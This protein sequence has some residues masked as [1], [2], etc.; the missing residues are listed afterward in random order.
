MA[1]RHVPLKVSQKHKFVLVVEPSTHRSTF[2]VA[3][4]HTSKLRLS[5]KKQ[6]QDPL[7]A[8]ESVVWTW[9]HA[10]IKRAR[11]SWA[12]EMESMQA[13]MSPMARRVLLGAAD[14]TIPAA[15]AQ[16][17]SMSELVV[18]VLYAIQQYFQVNNQQ[19]RQVTVEMRSLKG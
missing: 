9:G 3:R 13:S 8:C 19:S 2:A 1:A 6:L 12:E 17:P 16:A 14:A 4:A 15:K 7:E 11:S 18:S 5:K 10:S